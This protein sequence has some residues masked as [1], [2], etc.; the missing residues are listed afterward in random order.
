[1]S[2]G[3]QS[4]RQ[5]DAMS[6]EYAAENAESAYNA[7]HERPASIALLGKVDGRR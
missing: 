7:H 5:Y 1:M 6:V 3:Q 4:A 2:D